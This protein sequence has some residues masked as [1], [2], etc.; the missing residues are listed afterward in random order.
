MAAG[1]R[2]NDAYT[3]FFLHVRQ[4]AFGFVSSFLTYRSSLQQPHS[5]GAASQTVFLSCWSCNIFDHTGHEQCWV[6]QVCRCEFVCTPM[7]V[8]QSL[9]FF[10]LLAPSAVL[11]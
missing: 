3:S 11:P 7:A 5:P 10:L 6:V 8:P 9:A 4:L 1:S 2:R